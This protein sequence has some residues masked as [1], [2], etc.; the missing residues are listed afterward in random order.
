MLVAATNRETRDFDEFQTKQMS[1]PTAPGQHDTAATTAAT[2]VPQPTAHIDGGR[3]YVP[4]RPTEQGPMLRAEL[5]RLRDEIPPTMELLARI[6]QRLPHWSAKGAQLAT[7]IADQF[8]RVLSSLSTMLSNHGSEWIEQGLSGGGGLT[9]AEF[10]QL[11][12]DCVRDFAK[13]LGK[14]LAFLRDESRCLDLPCYGR[15]PAGYHFLGGPT[16]AVFST[17]DQLEVL[18]QVLSATFG[19]EMAL[20][21]K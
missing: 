4:P 15:T 16:P 17:L 7:D 2:S 8:Q 18:V 13:Q 11:D 14:T 3:T 12:A 9:Y 20:A 21:T 6:S 5:Y 1:I 19:V 10:S